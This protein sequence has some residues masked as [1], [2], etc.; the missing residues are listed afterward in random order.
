MRAAPDSWLWQFRQVVARLLVKL[1]R[2][3]LDVG[4]V[5]LLRPVVRSNLLHRDRD[6]LLPVAQHVHHVL[7]DRLGEP[8]LLLLGLPGPELHDDVRHC[9]PLP[10]FH[11]DRRRIYLRY[12]S[13]VT[14]SIQSTTLPSSASWMATCVM[15]VVGAAPCQC[16]SPGGDQTT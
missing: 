4:P 7:G 9:F 13:S 2:L 1:L 16:F 8:G 14:C 15:A 10:F 3:A 5:D 12:C 11:S 6:G